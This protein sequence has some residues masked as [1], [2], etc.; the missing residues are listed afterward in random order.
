MLAAALQTLTT[1]LEHDPLIVQRRFGPGE[2]VV[3]NNVLHSRSAFVD[4]PAADGGRL[5]LRV[6]SYDHLG[7]AT[8][9]PVTPVPQAGH[10]TWPSSAT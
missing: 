6:R 8:A 5:M 4:A 3:C 1:V 9:D 2:G 7:A 10:Q